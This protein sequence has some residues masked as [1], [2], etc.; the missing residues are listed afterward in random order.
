MLLI[1]AIWVPI[2]AIVALA[3][4]VGIAVAAG[5]KRVP[6][7]SIDLGKVFVSKQSTVV[8]WIK[9]IKPD[10]Q[11]MSAVVDLFERLFPKCLFVTHS[12]ETDGMIVINMAGQRTTWKKIQ[13]V[14]STKFVA[15]IDADPFGTQSEIYSDVPVGGAVEAVPQPATIL[16][17]ITGTAR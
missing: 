6:C 7:A 1:G 14:L 2:L 13:D 10:D 3:A 5:G 12:A 17:A 9:S 4:G 11:A 8:S 16:G 15:D